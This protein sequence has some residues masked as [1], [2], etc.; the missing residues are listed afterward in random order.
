[1]ADNKSFYYSLGGVVVAGAMIGMMAFGISAKGNGP[2]GG[3]AVAANGAAL[4]PGPVPNAPKPSAADTESAQAEMGQGS[5]P[6][7]APRGLE[8]AN[9][10]SSSSEPAVP[11]K[12]PQMQ[13]AVD[14]D[15]PGTKFVPPA[16]TSEMPQ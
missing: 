16:A 15:P 8:S 3:G 1:M 12:E 9:A 7:D 13:G 5:N 10:T 14:A 6:D 2:Q 11:V 4:G